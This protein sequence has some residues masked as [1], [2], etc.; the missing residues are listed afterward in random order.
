MTDIDINKIVEEVVK[1]LNDNDSFEV[2]ASGRHVHLSREAVDFLFGENYKLT[3]VKELSQPNQFACKERI[4]IVG[5]KGRFDSVVILAPERPACQVEISL[6]DALKL[7]IDAPVKESGDIAKTPAITLQNGDK[8]LE[9]KEGVIVAKRHIHI[10]EQDATRF[11]VV[12][13]EMVKVRVNTSRPIIFEDVVVRV[14]D[15]FSTSMHI[16][17]DEANACGLKKGDRGTIIRG[18]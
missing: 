5:E 11:N 12:N 2:E 9:L 6:T 14:S 16:D 8:V 10:T 18:H 7:G 17:Y 13:G 15:K 1:K 4:S 3:Y